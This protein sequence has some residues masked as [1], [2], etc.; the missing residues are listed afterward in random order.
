M[1]NLAIR[2]CTSPPL[3][4]PILKIFKLKSTTPPGIGPR[5][6]WTRGKHATIWAN[7]AADWKYLL[8]YFISTQYLSERGKFKTY[9]LRF[10]V[11]LNSVYVES[12]HSLSVTFC[13][14]VIYLS[15]K[16]LALNHIA[17]TLV[18]PTLWQNF[19][20]LFT[21]KYCVR[22]FISFLTLI[23]IKKVCL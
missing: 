11:I 19:L 5:S 3:L 2:K 17:L 15:E 16:G 14:T 4:A 20:K 12:L 21:R 8:P 1:H 6:C 13:L 7:A 22:A 23:Y 10:K 9:L 18:Y